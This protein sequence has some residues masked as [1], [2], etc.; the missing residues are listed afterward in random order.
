[1]S[2]DE[3]RARAEGL[4]HSFGGPWLLLEEYGIE[5]RWALEGG[6]SPIRTERF[7]VPVPVLL[8][9]LPRELLAISC[10][11]LNEPAELQR[12]LCAVLIDACLAWRL[13]EGG[14]EAGLH[15]ELSP[16]ELRIRIPGGLLEGVA[17]DEGVP[18]SARP[19]NLHLA[20][21]LSE[22]GFRTDGPEATARMAED[23]GF[24]LTWE[25]LGD[26]LRI[27]LR[28]QRDLVRAATL[29]RRART[30]AQA[31]QELILDHLRQ[32]PGR[33]ATNR[34]LRKVGIRRTTLS[35][36]LKVLEAAGL[37]RPT[38]VAR[39][40]KNQAWQLVEDDPRA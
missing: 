12:L 11:E 40:S 10:K 9:S 8:E 21:L 1:M 24:L 37:V 3:R 16:R 30:P 7:G 34:Q 25:E 29:S 28:R 19:R 36:D 2:V 4:I 13:E 33:R 15:L 20:S 38:E 27:L 18:D 14:F 32:M 23:Q 17:L 35:R 22:H 31:R 5:L 6:V 26:Q 39:S